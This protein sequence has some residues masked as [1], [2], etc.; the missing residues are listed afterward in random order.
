MIRS[1]NQPVSCPDSMTTGFRVT[2][3]ADSPLVLPGELIEVGV[4]PQH[5]RCPGVRGHWVGGRIQ[6][7][8]QLLPKMWRM[9]RPR[10]ARLA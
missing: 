1:T 7:L 9:R 5:T 8:L 10:T 3:S 6:G 4:G 2:Q